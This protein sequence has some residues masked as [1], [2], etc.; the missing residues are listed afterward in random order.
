[1]AVT[2][3]LLPAGGENTERACLSVALGPP[4]RRRCPWGSV[5]APQRG[6]LPA[7]RT[8]ALARVARMALPVG[9]RTICGRA[10]HH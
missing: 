7:G 9:L 5:G 4:R 2:F 1:M 6:R 8:A 10:E 3:A